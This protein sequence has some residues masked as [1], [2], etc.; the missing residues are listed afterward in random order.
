[1][2]T[3]R[4]VDDPPMPVRGKYDWKM[5]TTELKAN[6]TQWGVITGDGTKGTVQAAQAA[7]RNIRNGAVAGIKVGDF[8]ATSRGTV[9]YARYVGG[10]GGKTT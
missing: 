8:E 4:F 5:I 7:A 10:A 1:M 6:P 3:L 2:S 9:V